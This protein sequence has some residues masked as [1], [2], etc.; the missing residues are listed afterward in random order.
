MPLG[1]GHPEGVAR[2]DPVGSLRAEPAILVSEPDGR[3]V[4]SN[5]PMANLQSAGGVRCADYLRGLPNAEGLPC[6]LGCTERLAERPGCGNRHTVRVTGQAFVLACTRVSDR[7]ISVLTP[8]E[9]PS[10]ECANEPITGRERE[11]LQRLADGVSAPDIA[12]QL[13]V[14]HGTVRTHI[15]HLREKLGANTQAG[16]VGRA[17][18]L[19]I[20][21]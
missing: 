21:P 8:A 14:G 15:Q 17:F 18:R 3:V 5:A 10:R 1:V 20:L 13:G 6:R 12:M 7:I 4:G 9:L 16:V 11:V 19:K 2:V